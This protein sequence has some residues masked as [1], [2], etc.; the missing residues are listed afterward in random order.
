MELDLHVLDSM[1]DAAIDEILQSWAGFCAC[2][3][4]LLGGSGGAARFASFVRL[5]C[6]HGLASLVQD[7]FLHALEVGQFTYIC[8]IYLPSPKFI[9]LRFPFL[10]NDI[11]RQEQIV[12][13]PS[14]AAE[15][16]IVYYMLDIFMGGVTM[17]FHS[18][19]C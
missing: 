18:L 2:T 8:L 1:D 7:H 16:M 3:E 15:V 19:F 10:I 9:Y 17:I 12:S 6:A 13:L 11:N 14:A 5:L 4:A